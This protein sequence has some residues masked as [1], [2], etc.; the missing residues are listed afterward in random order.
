[1]GASCEAFSEKKVKLGSDVIIESGVELG[2]RYHD[3]AGFCVVGDHSII[4]YGSIIYS[5]V[6]LGNYF[7]GGHHIVI[8]AKVKAGDFCNI[9]NHSV[10]EG[11]IRLG[12]GVRIMSRVYIPTRTWV[13]DDVFIGPG[14]VFLN[15]RY[16]GRARTFEEPRGPIVEDNVTIGGNCTINP[17][18]RIGE[19]SFIASNTN[20]VKDIPPFSLVLGNPG[21]IQELPEHLKGENNRELTRAKLDLWHPNSRDIDYLEWPKEWGESFGA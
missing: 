1:M 18:I 7:Q 9:C 2:F 17:G 20:V 16:P 14:T 11:L 21:R 15:D 13:G 3:R 6:H 12:V 19:G 5:D 4:R 8:R 10:L